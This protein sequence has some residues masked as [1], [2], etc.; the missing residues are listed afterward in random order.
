MLRIIRRKIIILPVSFLMN[1]L[2]VL[3]S[4]MPYTSFALTGGPSQPEMSSFT[5]AGQEQ[6]VDPFTGNFSYNIPLMEIGGYPINIAYN[7]GITMEQ[8]ASWAGT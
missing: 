6:M 8:E 1:M 2:M 3:Y 4:V 5:P 7:A